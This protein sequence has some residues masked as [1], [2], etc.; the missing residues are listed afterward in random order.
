MSQEPDPPEINDESG[1][2]FNACWRALCLYPSTAFK[3][4]VMPGKF[5]ESLS[6]E[7]YSQHKLARATVFLVVSAV[8]TVLSMYFLQYQCTVFE[9]LDQLMQKTLYIIGMNYVFAVAMH[10][11]LMVF[12]SKGDILD[13]VESANYCSAQYLLICAG[14]LT[15]VAVRAAVPY[16][17]VSDSLLQW[18]AYSCVQPCITYVS[19]V[20]PL[21]G[22]WIF[23]RGIR[24]SRK[25]SR[26]KSSVAIFVPV[27]LFF[28]PM[29]LAAAITAFA[30]G[31]M[32]RH[33]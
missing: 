10:I 5:F 30:M 26:V 19:L 28:A 17:S 4:L 16:T 11:A 33:Q 13:T 25:I 18:F 22:C 12:G 20:F 2:L 6:A 1:S 24:A 7:S 15:Q 14:N 29:I 27:I 23:F 21:Y 8:L 9:C 3:A 31:M 32:T